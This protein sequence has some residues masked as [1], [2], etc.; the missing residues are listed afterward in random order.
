MVKDKVID[1]Y[2]NANEVFYTYEL[3]S[4]FNSENAINY[5]DNQRAKVNG[6]LGEGDTITR[7]I[8]LENTATIIFYDTEIRQATIEN[9]TSL[10]FALDGV[11]I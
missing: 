10:D 5:F 3:T 1:M 8:D 9:P 7:D 4:N 2:L 11:L 6:N